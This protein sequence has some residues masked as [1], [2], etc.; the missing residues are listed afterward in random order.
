LGADKD[1]AK[2]ELKLSLEFEI[3]LA[4]ISVPREERRN[5]TKF[6]HPKKLGDIGPDVAAVVTNWTEYIGRLLTEDVAQV[7]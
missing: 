2:E 4:E 1:R 7:R 3:N 6:Y 5:A